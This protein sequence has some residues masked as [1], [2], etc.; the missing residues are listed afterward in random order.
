MKRLIVILVLAVII[1]VPELTFAEAQEPVPSDKK[2]NE[3]LKGVPAPRKY[4]A[5]PKY[6]E[7]EWKKLCDIY[8]TLNKNAQ[9]LLD[10]Q[11]DIDKNAGNASVTWRDLAVME[12]TGAAGLVCFHSGQLLMTVSPLW[13]W[14]RPRECELLG[15][16]SRVVSALRES[17]SMLTHALDA[18]GQACGGIRNYA[19]LFHVDKA[20]EI[21]RSSLR[22]YD[23][24]IQILEAKQEKK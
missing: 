18:S 6:S 17:K 19:T 24:A 4:P 20:R 14:D 12:Q 5:P 7:K 10:I 8:D 15:D 21:M 1:W 16:E 11:R 22:L 23:K 9:A 3:F 13:E 2:W